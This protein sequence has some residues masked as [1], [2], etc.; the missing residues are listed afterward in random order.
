[1][2]RIHAKAILNGAGDEDIRRNAA[3]SSG[4]TVEELR[5]AGL[6]EPEK[7]LRVRKRAARSQ[8][9]EQMP[10]PETEHLEQRP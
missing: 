1:M 5:A 8:I 7:K 2:D 6:T 4:W 9:P 3:L 10:T